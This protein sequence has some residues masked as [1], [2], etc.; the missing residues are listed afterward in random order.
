MRYRFVFSDWFNRNLKALGKR[1]LLL[2]EEIRR[3]LISFDA[4]AHPII[5]NTGGARKARIGAKGRGKRGGYRMVYYLAY[6]ETVWLITIYDKVQKEDLSA[7]DLSQIA[8]LVLE[9]RS[10]DSS[11]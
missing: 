9:I 10:E 1:N 11:S 8:K 4:E 3:F 7:A 2:R 5:P 6:A